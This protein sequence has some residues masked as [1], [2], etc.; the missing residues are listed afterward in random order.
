MSDT[1]PRLK[2]ASLVFPSERLVL[3]NNLALS[4]SIRINS[5]ASEANAARPSIDAFRTFLKWLVV[6]YM[7]RD[8][9]RPTAEIIVL[10]GKHSSVV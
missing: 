1:L 5:T 4:G 8:V 2:L 10:S 6:V 7:Q 3:M 9:N